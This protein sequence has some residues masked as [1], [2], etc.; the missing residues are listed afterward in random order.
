MATTLA[1]FSWWHFNAIPLTVLLVAAS[2]VLKFE[3]KY[4]ILITCATRLTAPEAAPCS[5]A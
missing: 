2:E 1:E 3:M 5:L 4:A